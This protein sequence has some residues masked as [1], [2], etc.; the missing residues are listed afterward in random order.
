[1]QG[2][3]HLSFLCLIN[4]LEYF[5]M[6]IWALLRRVKKRRIKITKPSQIVFAMVTEA[7][8]SGKTA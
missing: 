8:F 2:P 5:E 6:T 1:M 3:T 7:M 4:F